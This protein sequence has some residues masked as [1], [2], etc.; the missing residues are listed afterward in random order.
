[1]FVYV[2][3][4]LLDKSGGQFFLK[5]CILVKKNCTKSHCSEQKKTEQIE[6]LGKL[7]FVNV[8]QNL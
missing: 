1:M 7:R 4:G 8:V 6:Y 5:L 3:L 2:S